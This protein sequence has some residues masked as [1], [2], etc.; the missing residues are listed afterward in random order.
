MFFVSAV[1]HIHTAIDAVCSAI[2]RKFKTVQN[3]QR[4]KD[5]EIFIVAVQGGGLSRG[6]AAEKG[7]R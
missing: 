7:G 2:P 6:R 5:K 1:T 4:E 3:N